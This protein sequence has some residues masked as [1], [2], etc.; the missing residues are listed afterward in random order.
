MSRVIDPEQGEESIGTLI[1]RL[2]EDGKRYARAEIG[3]YKLLAT[4]KL[5][6]AGLGIG[7]GLVALVLL[8]STL[9]ALLVGVILALVPL[10]GA[11]WA[12][13]IVVVAALLIAGLFGWIAYRQI[14][15][16]FGGGR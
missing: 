7:F 6:E 5:R 16:A 14:A 2:T 3:Y 15:K 4:T 8:C 10:V 12:T 13:A 1:G 11:G 9:T